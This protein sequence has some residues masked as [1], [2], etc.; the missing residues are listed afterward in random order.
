VRA[1]LVL[2]VV[3]LLVGCGSSSASK[4]DAPLDALHALGRSTAFHG[5][6]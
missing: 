2:A 1:L 4:S 5:S 6:G 3:A